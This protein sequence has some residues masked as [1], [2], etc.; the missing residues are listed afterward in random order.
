VSYPAAVSYAGNNATGYPIIQWLSLFGV[1]KM[2]GFSA[3]E[4][5]GDNDV[6]ESA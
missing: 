4:F 3:A 6:G 2:K 1:R 5:G